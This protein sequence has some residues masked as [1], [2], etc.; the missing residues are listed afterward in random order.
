LQW[1]QGQTSK[2][3]KSFYFQFNLVS[4]AILYYT[5]GP[6][7]W[8]KQIFTSTMIMAC[9]PYQPK[10]K[11]PHLLLWT[12]HLRLRTIFLSS[13]VFS[14]TED[15]SGTNRTMIH[16]LPGPTN[17]SLFKGINVSTTY[18]LPVLMRPA[19]QGIPVSDEHTGNHFTRGVLRR[20]Q[21]HFSWC[22]TWNLYVID[23]ENF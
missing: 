22:V 11:V 13:P 10:C 7:F 3:C 18:Q 16:W 23:R 1:S 15:F 20:V 12:V 5:N 21:A 8:I 4:Y 17:F 19:R 14:V 2:F 9:N 6:C